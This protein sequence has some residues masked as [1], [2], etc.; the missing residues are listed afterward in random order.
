MNCIICDALIENKSVEHIIPDALGGCITCN[1]ICDRCNKGCGEEIDC[2][3]T[4]SLVMLYVRDKLKIRNRDNKTVSFVNHPKVKWK[5]KIT[6]QIENIGK[7]G[8]LLYVRT[9]PKLKTIN[10]T[11][12]VSAYTIQDIEKKLR[13]NNINRSIE[14]FAYSIA[15]FNEN[16][17][18]DMLISP[19]EIIPF[20]IK[21][22]YEFAIMNLG[23]NYKEDFIGKRYKEFLCETIKNKRPACNFQEYIKCTLFKE[24]DKCKDIKTIDIYSDEHRIYL[25]MNLFEVIKATILLTT[26]PQ[27]YK[28]F[29]TP[30]F[31]EIKA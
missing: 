22:A 14:D 24:I 21:V 30:N 20:I 4:D 11:I 17:E 10:N 5:N 2:K 16:L 7:D 3:F 28:D 6:G 27:K 23:D 31:I 8:E 29:K 12:N 9:K 19:Q 25:A 26:E 15:L 18:C 1:S 13:R